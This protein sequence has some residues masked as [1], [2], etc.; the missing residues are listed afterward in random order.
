MLG[1][2]TEGRA[3][4]TTA[5]TPAGQAYGLS[6]DAGV[7]DYWWPYGPAVDRYSIKISGEQT[8]G[9]LLQLHGSGPGVSPPLHIHHDADETWYVIAGELVILVGDERIR[10]G[11]GDFV[12]GPR[13]IPHSF[14]VA[15]E[16]AEFLVTF[17]PAGTKGPFGFGVDGFFREVAVPVVPGEPPPQ[18]REPDTEHF[19]QRMAAYGIELVGPPPTLD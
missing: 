11:A 9:G 10:A 15:S 17:A 6:R 7:S 18:P 12:L 3:M 5:T 19:A 8:D 4:S 1:S 16:R 2:P 14:V 13:G